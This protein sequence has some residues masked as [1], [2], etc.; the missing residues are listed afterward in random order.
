MPTCVG[1]SFAKNS[2]TCRR[3][4]FFRSTGCSLASTPCTTKTLLD[5]SIPIRIRSFTDGSLCLRSATTSFWHTDA[6]GG[7]PPQQ[8]AAPPWVL[9]RNERIDSNKTCISIGFVTARILLIED[10]PRLAE[11]VQSYLGGAG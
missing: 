6:V 4:S 8:G 3:R 2:I 9:P 1:G 7:R 11:M 5:V 10:D